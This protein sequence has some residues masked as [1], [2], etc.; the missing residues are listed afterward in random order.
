VGQSDQYEFT[1]HQGYIVF[2]KPAAFGG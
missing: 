2:G 1:H